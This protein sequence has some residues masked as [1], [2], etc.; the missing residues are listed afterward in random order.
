MRFI[1][2]SSSKTGIVPQ[3]HTLSSD[4]TRASV[5]AHGF[6]TTNEIEYSQFEKGKLKNE[7]LMYRL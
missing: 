7:I 4:A 5:L 1:A 3:V 6:P 2:R